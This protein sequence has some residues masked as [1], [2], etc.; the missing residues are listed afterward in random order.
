MCIDYSLFLS[1]LLNRDLKS[2]CFRDTK[3]QQASAEAIFQSLFQSLC[4]LH[5]LEMSDNYV[6]LKVNFLL[7]VVVLV[8]CCSLMCDEICSRLIMFLKLNWCRLAHGFQ[9][10]GGLPVISHYFLNQLLAWI[11]FLPWIWGANFYINGHMFIHSSR[12]MQKSVVAL[13][14]WKWI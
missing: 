14:H 4:R 5:S 12:L 10:W 6:S 2:V 1:I 3:L 9:I 8:V 7:R 11:L 13:D